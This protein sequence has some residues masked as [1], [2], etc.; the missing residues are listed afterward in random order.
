MTAVAGCA[1]Y[2]LHL[3]GRLQVCCN[4]RIRQPRPNEL[5]A[6]KSDG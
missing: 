1:K 2:L 6:N 5:K 4:G 3:S